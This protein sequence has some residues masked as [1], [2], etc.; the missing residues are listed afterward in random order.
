MNPYNQQYGQQQQPYGQQQQGYGQQGPQ[1]GQGPNQPYQS[2][3]MQPQQQYGSPQMQPYGQQQFNQPPQYGSPQMQ[4]FGQQ[5]QYGSPQMQPYGQQQQFGGQGWMS[6]QFSGPSQFVDLNQLRQAFDTMD[7]NHNGQIDAHE[8][9]K[10]MHHLGEKV[11][12]QDVSSI[13]QM[14]DKNHNGTI[15]FNEFQQL[16][17]YINELK[18]EFNNADTNKSGFLN[19]DQVKQ[20]LHKHHKA[21]I[22]AGGA[23]TVYSLFKI[24]DIKKKENLD[25]SDFLKMS[26]HLGS[27]RSGYETQQFGQQQFGQQQFGQQGYGGYQQK[28]EG[29]FENFA[30]WAES[31][32]RR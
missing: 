24:H 1:Y 18:Q 9:E 20:A 16:W 25:W 12:S 11:N 13:M 7:K 6:Q 5:Q 3:S 14:Y 26:L 31:H 8:L 22:L 30:N 10:A 4:Q 23:A 15:D 28:H 19:F 32:F 27:L 2:P 17:A 29:M 21:L